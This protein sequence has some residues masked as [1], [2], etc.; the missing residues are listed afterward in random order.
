MWRAKTGKCFHTFR[1]HTVEI[2]HS[3]DI[4]SLSFNTVGDQLVT[5]SFDHTVSLWDVPSGRRVHTLIGHRG[6]IISVQFDWDCSLL[7]TGSMDKSSRAQR[8]C[9]AL[10]A[11]SASPDWRDTTERY[12]RSVL[13]LKPVEFCRPAL[14]RWLACGMSSLASIFRS[15]RDTWTRSSPP[16]STARV[17]PSQFTEGKEGKAIWTG[18]SSLTPDVHPPTRR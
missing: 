12:P 1:G 10:P 5:G 3:A 16:P 2:G 4:I 11:T 14:T 8:E 6:E 18:D 17:T 7:I 13:T 15:W 9:T